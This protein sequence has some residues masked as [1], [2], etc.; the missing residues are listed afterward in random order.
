MGFVHGDWRHP[1]SIADAWPGVGKVGKNA[2]GD[3]FP[4][5]PAGPGSHVAGK[6][7]PSG[8]PNKVL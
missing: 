7:P 1:R 8:G 2:A 3:T 5:Q 6:R 4:F